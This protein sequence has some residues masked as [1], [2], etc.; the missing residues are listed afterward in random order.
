M[1]REEEI[2]VLARKPATDIIAELECVVTP[3]ETAELKQAYRDITVSD[4]VTGYIMDIVSA[5]RAESRLTNGVSTRG[6]R[7]LYEACQVSAALDGRSYVIPEDVKR[8]AGP[9]LA[10]RVASATD[11][12]VDAEAYLNEL[13]ES[14][15]VPLEKIR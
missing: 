15:C 13:V 4:D 6:A 2:K 9:V 10:H 12:R 14:I 1:T 11:S 7:A 5:T 3:S 8:E